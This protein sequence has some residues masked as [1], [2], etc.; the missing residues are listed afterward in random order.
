MRTS[1]R[2][3]VRKPSRNSF[4]AS[5]RGSAMLRGSRLRK[6][7]SRTVAYRAAT[8]RRLR[9]T[10]SL[11]HQGLMDPAAEGAAAHLDPLAV[12]GQGLQAGAPGQRAGHGLGRRRSL[13]QAGEIDLDHVAA[14][15]RGVVQLTGA[16]RGG[17]ACD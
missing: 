12:D 11:F 6:I 1:S 13:A 4:R 3:S 15:A 17:R 5:R 8:L 9:L 2:K 10:L 7:K 16:R 14:L